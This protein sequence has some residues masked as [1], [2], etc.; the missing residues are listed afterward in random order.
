M[1]SIHPFFV[2]FI[3]H[4]VI[5]SMKSIPGNLGYKLGDTFSTHHKTPT[6][7]RAQSLSQS[8]YGQ[9]THLR[10]QSHYGQLEMPVSL[11]SMSLNWRRKLE[12]SEESPKAWV[13]NSAQS[14]EVGIETRTMEVQGI[15]ANY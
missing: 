8:H 14:G 3:L 9:P 10:A 1:V 7:H 15:H 4:R 11:C 13:E 2:V 6:H 12:Y 5:G